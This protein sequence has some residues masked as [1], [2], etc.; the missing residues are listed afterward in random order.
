MRLTEVSRFR[1][2]DKSKMLLNFLKSPVISSFVGTFSDEKLFH[3]D[4]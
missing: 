1:R 3:D 2:L 4:A